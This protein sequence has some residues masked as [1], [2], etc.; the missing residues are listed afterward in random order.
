ML[1]TFFAPLKKNDV[2]SEVNWLTQVW[3]TPGDNIFSSCHQWNIKAFPSKE[4]N[5]ECELCN[6][7]DTAKAVLQRKTGFLSA[8]IKKKNKKDDDVMWMRQ[9]IFFFLNYWNRKNLILLHTQ[10]GLEE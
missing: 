5:Y 7:S 10:R 2:K 3:V 8:Q 1:G 6:L 4:F 9:Q